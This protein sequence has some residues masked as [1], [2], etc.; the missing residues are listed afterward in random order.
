[1]HLL[2]LSNCHLQCFCFPH[3]LFKAV[4]ILYIRSQLYELL[5][6]LFL[7]FLYLKKLKG[8]LANLERQ[9]AHAKKQLEDETLLRVDL[10]NRL[11]STKEDLQF[12]TQMFEQVINEG[13]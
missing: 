11:Q 13:G 5:I 7:F 6:I 1:M 10:Q 12:K 2:F 9:L 4:G 3:G 8:E